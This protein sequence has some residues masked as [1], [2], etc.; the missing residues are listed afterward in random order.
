MGHHVLYRIPYPRDLNNHHLLTNSTS[1][2]SPTKKPTK[3]V[4]SFLLRK[5][6]QIDHLIQLSLLAVLLIVMSGDLRNYLFI[7]LAVALIVLHPMSIEKEVGGITAVFVLLSM[8]HGV[9][10]KEPGITLFGINGKAQMKLWKQRPWNFVVTE[11]IERRRS[12]V[13]NANLYAIISIN[14]QS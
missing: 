1:S 14:I 10:L 8:R 6:C 9:S 2:I 4:M 5:S 12:H 7:E 11:I 3:L 13:F